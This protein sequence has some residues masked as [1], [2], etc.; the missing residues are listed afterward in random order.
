[1]AKQA[2]VS[3]TLP[4][5]NDLFATETSVL[6]IDTSFA[7]AKRVE[8]DSHSWIEAVPAWIS[9]AHL[10][11]DR[12]RKV[13]LWREH[14]RKMFDQIVREPR[15]TATYRSLNEVPDVG[16]L[17]AV[18]ALSDHYG[19]V[20]DSIWMNLYRD[21][22]DSTAWHRDYHSC[23]RAECIVPVLSLGATRKFLIKPRNGGRSI[24]FRPGSGD[25]IVMG[26]RSQQDW[27]HA[28]PKEPGITEARISLNFQ[29]GAQ[30]TRD[31][32][33]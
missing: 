29:S 10:L 7:T 30:A 6:A 21:G 16:L 11:F 27:V 3:K 8:L 31:G 14:D 13:V 33:A 1:M 4:P 22:Q 12:M 28:V 32:K 15:M 23:R 20:Y 26:G 9:G 25:L 2:K 5:Q 18:R 17:E 19:V 24:V